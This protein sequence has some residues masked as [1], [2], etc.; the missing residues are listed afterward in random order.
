MLSRHFRFLGYEVEVAEDA[1]VALVSME[2]KRFEVVISDISMPG[3]SGIE[4]LREIRKNS[5]MTQCIMITGYV[6]MENVLCC[7]RLGADTCI[8]KPLE[9]MR[10]LEDAVA[11]AIEH[12]KRWQS[13]LKTLLRMKPE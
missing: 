13:K 3:M 6:T 2:K 8:F 9:D 11:H 1:K 4:L 12:L 7:M 5:P 10:E